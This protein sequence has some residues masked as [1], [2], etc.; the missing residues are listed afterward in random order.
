M[1]TKHLNIIQLSRVATRHKKFS[2][3][4]HNTPLTNIMY[5]NNEEKCKYV[6]IQSCVKCHYCQFCAFVKMSNEGDVDY[7]LGLK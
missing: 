3:I 1:N 6:R 4:P 2:Q 7:V 5:V